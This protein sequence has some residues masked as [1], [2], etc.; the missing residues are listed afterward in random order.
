MDMVQLI[1]GNLETA[2]RIEGFLVKLSSEV[3]LKNLEVSPSLIKGIIEK[4]GGDLNGQNIKANPVQVISAVSKYF[5]LGKRALLGVSRARPVA[6]PRQILMYI[7]RIELSLP[8][9]EVGRLTGGRDHTTVMHAV[10]KITT[11]ASEDVKIRED[12]RG[13]KNL[14]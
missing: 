13:I 1:A 10:N 12:I 8:L 6:R 14:L 11:L 5:S 4:G 9:E 3:N 7:L 2:R